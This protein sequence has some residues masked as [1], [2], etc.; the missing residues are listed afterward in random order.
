MGAWGTEPLQNDGVLDFIDGL[1]NSHP[2]TRVAKAQAALL[3]YTAF[4]ARLQS[5]AN[6]SALSAQERAELMASRE[7]ALL[8]N[9]GRID[10][11]V[12]LMPEYATAASWATYVEEM[13]QPQSDDGGNEAEAAIGAAWA[14]AA[15]LGKVPRSGQGSP[16]AAA[17]P[18]ELAELARAARPVLEAIAANPLLRATWHAKADEWAWHLHALRDAL[19][20]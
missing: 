19:A 4:H 18:A 11:L 6:I 9:A 13:A 12:T 15:A 17:A 5:G 8:A 3:A 1:A 2:A 10:T 20:G 16:L 7:E 14:A